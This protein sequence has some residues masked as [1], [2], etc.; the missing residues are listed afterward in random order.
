MARHTCIEP[1]VDFRSAG[2]AQLVRERMVSDMKRNRSMLSGPELRTDGCYVWLGF[3][4]LHTLL[5]RT[6]QIDKSC[7]LGSTFS[8]AVDGAIAASLKAE[9]PCGL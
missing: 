8:D 7:R 4:L 2:T 6:N 3:A 1:A 5:A 9:R